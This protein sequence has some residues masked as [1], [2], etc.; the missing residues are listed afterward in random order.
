MINPIYAESQFLHSIQ[1][2]GLW[3][4]DKPLR[5]HLGCGEN[6]FNGYINI[7]LPPSSHTV[8]TKIGADIF[9]D[10]TTLCIPQNTVDEVRTHA[11]FEHFNRVNALALLCQWYDWLKEGGTLIFDVPDFE[12]CIKRFLEPTCSYPEKQVI[13]R[14]L[15]GSQEAEW[16]LHR[17]G[18]YID[19][20]HHVLNMLGFEVTHIERTKW[21]ALRDIVVHAKK[22]TSYTRAQLAD[23]AKKILR[24]SMVDDSASEQREWTV[25]C[26]IFDQLFFIENNS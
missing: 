11:V 25:W 23:I 20:A 21:L 9:A 3:S 22:V 17:D 19:K 2:K 7:D 15:Y 16:A 14:H 6:H 4:A 26:S 8:Q 1:Q 10:F 24:E 5:L 18:W 12:A 13:L